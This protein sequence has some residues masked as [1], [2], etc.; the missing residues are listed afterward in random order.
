MRAV[1][2]VAMVVVGILLLLVESGSDDLVGGV[3]LTSCVDGTML[4][5]LE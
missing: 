4:M 3:D 1:M 5:V 2:S